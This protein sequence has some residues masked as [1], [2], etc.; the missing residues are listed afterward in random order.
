VRREILSWVEKQITENF[1]KGQLR[2]T[3]IIVLFKGN[4]LPKYC[5]SMPRNPEPPDELPLTNDFVELFLSIAKNNLSI[6]DGAIMIRIDHNPPILKGFSFR[7]YPPPLIVRREKNMGSGYNSALDFSGVDRVL[8]V[9]F[10]NKTG[11]RKF[12]KDREV[13]IC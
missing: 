6:K 13:K 10:I 9:Y 7:L 4:S 3:H 2:S 12:I 8:C 11:V 1:K 5:V